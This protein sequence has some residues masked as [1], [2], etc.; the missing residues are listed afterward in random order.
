MQLSDKTFHLSTIRFASTYFL[1]SN[2]LLLLNN[3]LLCPLLPALS[4][5]KSVQSYVIIPIN[6]FISLD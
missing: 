3:F 2:L 4:N 5:L 6:Y 1:I